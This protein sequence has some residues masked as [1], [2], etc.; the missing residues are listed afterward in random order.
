M[1][2]PLFDLSGRNALVTGSSRGLGRAI[3]AGLA[4]AGARLIVNG[5]DAGR[6]A[7]AVAELGARGLAAVAAPF[8]VTDERQVAE[9]IDRIEREIGPIDILVNNA[10]IQRRG[11][12]E[13]I[14]EADWQAVIDLN[15]T[16][17]WRVA[18][19]AARGMIG[20]G[21]GRIINIASLMS[22]AGRATTGPY[23]ASKGGVAMLTKAMSVEWARHGIN[24]NALAP[25]YFLT[26]MTRKLA[27]DPEFD[28]WVRMR[29]PA[30]RWGEPRELVGP[31]VFLASEAASFVNGQ[32]LYVDGGWSA[33]L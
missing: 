17:V 33:K 28:G 14:D 20:R 21:R 12:L 22:F 29:T 5:T 19:F 11:P 32:V 4:Q 1:S 31:A 2:S 13:Q 23:T 27:Q 9:A 25:G 15:L 16:A 3:G 6:V 8:D 7:E 26:D 18:K 30:E 24:V 10:G